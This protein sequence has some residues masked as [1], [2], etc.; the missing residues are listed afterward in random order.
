MGAQRPDKLLDLFDEAA[1]ADHGILGDTRDWADSTALKFIT[2]HSLY[3]QV[4]RLTLGYE[5]DGEVHAPLD[6]TDDDQYTR[7]NVTV[8]RERGSTVTVEV[9]DGPLGT[10]EIGKY[11][12]QIN[13]N[14][15]SEDRKS[16]A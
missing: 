15:E 8:E 6:P 11:D 9:T 10:S 1:E 3:N 16:A 7:N 13:L 12:T 4:P 5:D 14:T 2:R